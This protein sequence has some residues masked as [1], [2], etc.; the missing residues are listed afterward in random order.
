M[1]NRGNY[2]MEVFASEGAKFA[3]EKA[4]VDVLSSYGWRLHAYVIMT[5]HY[6]LAVETPLPNLVDGMHALQSTFATRFNRLR[7]ERGHVFQGRYQSL[8]VENSFALSRLVDYIHL[9]PVRAGIETF[10]SLGSYSWGSLPRFCKGERLPGQTGDLVMASRGLADTAQAWGD[11]RERLRALAADELEQK[12]LGFGEMSRGWA[13]GTSG[14][15]KAL[16]E[17]YAQESLTGMSREDAALIRTEKWDKSW[18]KALSE[19]G[20]RDVEAQAE[21]LATVN[22]HQRLQ[23]ALTLRGAGASYRWIAERLCLGNPEALRIRLFR[24]RNVTM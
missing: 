6:H 24:L 12:R 7:K 16:A 19:W 21:D 13:I 9:N 20:I 11:E 18:R 15:R 10:E 22:V 14:W 2:R 8:V 3:F 5:N 1:L 17:D 4:L 23:V